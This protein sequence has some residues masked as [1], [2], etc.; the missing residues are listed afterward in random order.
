YD[1]GGAPEGLDVERVVG[2][3]EL[4]R[5][6]HDD[7][8]DDENQEVAFDEVELGSEPGQEALAPDWLDLDRGGVSIGLDYASLLLDGFKLY[9]P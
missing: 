5:Q 8:A 6:V 4:A 2:R 9:T 7:P 3:G 1:G